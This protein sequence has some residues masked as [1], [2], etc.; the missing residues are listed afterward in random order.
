MATEI[1]GGGSDQESAGLRGNQ[2]TKGG[3]EEDPDVVKGHP[4]D[5]SGS[6]DRNTDVIA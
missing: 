1:M 5:P 3:P 4:E 2:T 6:A